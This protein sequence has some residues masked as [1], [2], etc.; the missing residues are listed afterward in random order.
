MDVTDAEMDRNCIQFEENNVAWFI[1]KRTYD[2]KQFDVEQDHAALRD[3]II[4]V[5]DAETDMY[6]VSLKHRVR[7]DATSMQ[8][9]YRNHRDETA[10]TTAAGNERSSLLWV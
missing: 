5:S 3:A 4:Q 8:A 10:A 2:A 7:P 6:A 9:V 1:G